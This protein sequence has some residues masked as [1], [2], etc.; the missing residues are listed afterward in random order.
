MV[1][2]LEF[3]LGRLTTF[4]VDLGPPTR[5]AKRISN[6]RGGRDSKERRTYRGRPV[7]VKSD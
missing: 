1:L 6:K 5:W 7:P 3:R 4:T 2:S